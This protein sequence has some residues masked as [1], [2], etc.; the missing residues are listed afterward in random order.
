MAAGCVACDEK[1]DVEIK[2]LGSRVALCIVYQIE[3]MGEGI[4]VSSRSCALEVWSCGRRSVGVSEICERTV[5]EK[6]P[7]PTEDTRT[8][9]A[10]AS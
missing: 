5:V 8:I 3:R 6:D 9:H 7:G 2:R 4:S 1:Q 10:L